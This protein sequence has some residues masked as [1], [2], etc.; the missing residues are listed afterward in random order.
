M[1]CKFWSTV[2]VY[3]K[4]M[5]GYSWKNIDVM[6]YCALN[7]NKRKIW[8]I[9]ETHYIWKIAFILTSGIVWHPIWHNWL[10]PS[11]M[12]TN[13]TAISLKKKTS[14]VQFIH[15]DKSY[16][17][18]LIF[19]TSGKQRVLI[20][21]QRCRMKFQRCQITW[22]KVPKLVGDG[23]ILIQIQGFCY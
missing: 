1:F 17:N 8:Q 3:Q 13:K 23:Q 6:Q 20:P 21:L 14:S 16:L 18:E 5:P 22:F 4:C 15:C 7:K 19:T 2:K 11:F 10:Q 12:N 9:W